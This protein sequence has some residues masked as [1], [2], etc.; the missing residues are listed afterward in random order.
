MPNWTSNTI[1]IKRNECPDD[2]W[3]I[4]QQAANDAGDS[5]TGKDFMQSIYPCPQDLIDTKA[6]FLTGKEGEE[7]AIKQQENIRKYGHKDWYDWR[8]NRWGTKWD[9]CEFECSVNNDEEVCVSGNTAWSYPQNFLDFLVEKG[10]DVECHFT[11]EDYD[12][13]HKYENG[14]VVTKHQVFDIILPYNTNKELIDNQAYSLVGENFIRQ[15]EVKA[16]YEAASIIINS[17]VVHPEYITAFMN[18]KNF[19]YGEFNTINEAFMACVSENCWDD[20]DAIRSLM[21]DLNDVC[22]P[23]YVSFSFKFEEYL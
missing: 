17:G 10:C 12:G 23:D 8:I 7:L 20:D 21:C 16:A 5:T 13:E 1:S 19:D 14:D 3:A 4:I 9:L 22:D 18:N 6:A 11:N 2:F 15:V